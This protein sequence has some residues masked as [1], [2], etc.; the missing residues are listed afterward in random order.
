VH[1]EGIRGRWRRSLLSILRA[2]YLVIYGWQDW[3]I[4]RLDDLCRRWVVPEGEAGFRRWY[5]SKRLMTLASPLCF[6]TH[7]AVMIVAL[8]L[9]RPLWGLYGIVGPMN[10]YWAGLIVY[11][12]VHVRRKGPALTSG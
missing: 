3:L 8:L 12:L 5:G 11:R 1:D 2:A 10:A 6:G 7:I 4:G 9:S